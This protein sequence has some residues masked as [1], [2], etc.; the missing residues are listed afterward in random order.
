MTQIWDPF[1]QQGAVDVTVFLGQWPFRYKTSA[2]AGD[3]SAMCDRLGLTGMCVSHIASVFGHDTRSGNEA[4]LAE[5]AG[6]DRLW[7]FVILN[8]GQS[9]WQRELT[10]AAESGAR[11]VRLVPGFH[12]YKLGDAS[13]AELTAA[14]RELGLPLQ[15]CARLQDLRLQHPKFV[16]AE[17]PLH[18][19][20]E[21]I[22]AASDLPLLI[23]GLNK[24]EWETMELH[25]HDDCPRTNLYGDLWFFNGPLAVIAL[26]CKLGQVNKFA[27]GSCFPIQN[28]EATVLQLAAA[29]I[30]EVERYALCSGNAQR[31]LGGSS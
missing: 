4:L 9:G 30:S 29:N 16:T 17:V 28:A 21:L 8:P 31:F 24:P 12:D 20:A 1:R 22:T 6:D 7:P 23:S 11:G 25:L 15:I 18:E 3:L 10:W 2:A 26:L 27:Y 19:L 14:L 13:V 5:A